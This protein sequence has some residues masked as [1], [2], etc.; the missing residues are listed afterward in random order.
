LQST[1]DP[2]AFALSG[3]SEPM[4]LAFVMSLGEAMLT[5]DPMIHPDEWDRNDMEHWRRKKISGG[6]KP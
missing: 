4:N 3:E 5:N 1:F 6:E 2:H